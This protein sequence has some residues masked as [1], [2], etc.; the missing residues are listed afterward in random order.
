MIRIVGIQKNEQPSGEFLLLQNQGGLR[1]NLRGIVVLSDLAVEAGSFACG[2]HVFSEDV[3]V[4]PG[5]F[6]LLQTGEGESRWAKTKDG[7]MVYYSYMGR[8]EIVW[9]RMCGPIHVLAAQHTYTERKDFA[10]L[11]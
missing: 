11:R 10:T 6:V 1:A 3:A 7:A 9:S 2:S 8:R 4:P 5:A